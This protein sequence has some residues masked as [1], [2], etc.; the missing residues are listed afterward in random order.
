[1]PLT[2]H[3]L[4]H[5]I[6]H[7]LHVQRFL[8]SMLVSVLFFC[9]LGLQALDSACPEAPHRSHIRH[10]ALDVVCSCECSYLI[11]PAYD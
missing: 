6:A 10:A 9:R 4:L 3:T 5:P 8:L 1:M 7:S 11:V 2:L